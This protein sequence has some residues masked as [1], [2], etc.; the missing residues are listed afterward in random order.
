MVGSSGE[1][2]YSNGSRGGVGRELRRSRAEVNGEGVFEV[3]E[4][5]EVEAMGCRSRARAGSLEEEADE[6]E[7]DGEREVERRE[8]GGGER[9]PIL[10]SPENGHPSSSPVSPHA[11]AGGDLVL[12]LF[13]GESGSRKNLDFV[14]VAS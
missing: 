11:M 10:T 1:G 9:E 12:L 4:T 13:G 3:R 8:A 14:I 5:F 6:K 2:E 7:T